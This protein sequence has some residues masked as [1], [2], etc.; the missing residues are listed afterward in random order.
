M[1]F[2]INGFGGQKHQS[3][4]RGFTFDQVTLC[5]VADMLAHG[6]LHCPAGLGQLHL[7]FG[8]TKR[9][10]GF[11]RKLAVDHNRPRRVG[12]MD[13]AIGALLVGKRGLQSIGVRWQRLGHDIIQLDLAKCAACLFVG[14]D[15]LQAQ[16]IAGEF[17]DIVLRPVDGGKAFLK[18]GQRGGRL[19]RRA[20]QGFFHPF[21]H[22]RQRP[23][24]AHHV[25]RQPVIH[26]LLY[27]AQTR[28]NGL[29]HLHLRVGLRVGHGLQTAAQLFLAH[30]EL[31][32]MAAKRGQL[33]GER[34][35]HAG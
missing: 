25:I 8:L 5:N 4:I 29:D 10:I 3:T 33:L 15:V 13:Q 23:V 11:Q 17:G 9:L 31:L 19:F 6:R 20:V 2:S 27:I 12:Q 34:F 16:Y 21:L 35:G 22:F 32:H 26:L 24:L 14:Q 18:L 1:Q 7:G 30:A 28:L